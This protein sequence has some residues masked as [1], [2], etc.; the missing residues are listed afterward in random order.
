MLIRVFMPQGFPKTFNNFGW[1][2]CNYFIYFISLFGLW[3]EWNVLVGYLQLNT[4][5]TNAIS[6]QCSDQ[7]VCPYIK[8][9]R[10]EKSL[11]INCDNPG[12]ITSNIDVVA[13]TH[14]AQ[15]KR[16]E[17]CLDGKR[18]MVGF[19][20]KLGD[21]DH[22]VKPTLAEKKWRLE[23]ELQACVDRTMLHHK[24]VSIIKISSTRLTELRQNAQISVA[25][26]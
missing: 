14:N 5:E 15:Q 21:V 4:I 23:I 7:F 17:L 12:I 18:L 6:M 11:Q 13:G 24:I 22:E 26:G 2:I 16:Y 20:S 25:A 9:L 8:L 3:V 19:G 1:Q 10:E